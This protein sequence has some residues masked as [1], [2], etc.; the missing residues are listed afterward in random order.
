MVQE[1]QV[2]AGSSKSLALLGQ[3]NHLLAA[4]PT[5]AITFHSWPLQA[6][7]SGAIFCSRMLPVSF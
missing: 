6:M 4:T 1:G 7:P 3:D 2:A 5:G